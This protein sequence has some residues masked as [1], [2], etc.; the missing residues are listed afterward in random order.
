[1][2]KFAYLGFPYI[3]GKKTSLKYLLPII[4]YCK[5]KYNLTTFIDAC[6]GGGSVISNVDTFDFD[7][8]IAND[9]DVG[10]YSLYKVLQDE[11][12]TKRLILEVDSLIKEKQIR[13]IFNEFLAAYQPKTD[14][15]EAWKKELLEKY[16]ILTLASKIMLLIFASNKSGMK[17]FLSDMLIKN[18]IDNR[19][20]LKLM[21]YH[22]VYRNIEVTNKD[23]FDY[24]KEW[25]SNE[26]TLIFLDVPYVE[27]EMMSEGHYRANGDKE[28]QERLVKELKALAENDKSAKII[29]CGYDND[30]YK[31]LTQDSVFYRY[32]VG[33]V[34]VRSAYHKNKLT[35]E[36]IKPLR[37]EFIWSNMIIPS[38][39]QAKKGEKYYEAN[40]QQK[41][42][43]KGHIETVVKN[44][45]EED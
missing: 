44:D 11:E 33:T 25:G 32:Y 43:K 26:E 14:D 16:D 6:T 34:P 7:K 21:E 19:I 24:L 42:L 45:N 31:T 28:F 29:L 13:K 41:L 15:L 9:L 30:F 27:D 5:S 37:N 3:G 2:K 40:R 4:K 12:L 22:E 18:F 17:S 8:R 39:F 36:S 1:M 38:K 10:M 20:H 35:G 23:L